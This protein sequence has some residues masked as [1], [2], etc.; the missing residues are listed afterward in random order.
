MLP[1]MHGVTGLLIKL[2]VRWVV[3]TVTFVLATRY[4]EDV[5]VSKKWAYPLIGGM[6]AVL[7]TAFYWLLAGAL[8]LATMRSLELALPLV[9]NTVLLIAMIRLSN[10]FAAHSPAAPVKKG[11][12]PPEKPQGWLRV[13][14]FFSSVWLA[15]MVTAAHGLLWFALDYVPSR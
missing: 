1:G 11:A 6:F 3:F 14:G 9:A 7:N 5:K 10:R 4:L 12:P 15:V 8:D 2:G 13:N